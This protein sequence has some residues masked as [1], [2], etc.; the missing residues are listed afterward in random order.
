MLSHNFQLSDGAIKD[1]LREV[2][3]SVL[4]ENVLFSV[5]FVIA[6]L[7]IILRQLTAAPASSTFVDQS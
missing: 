6:F 2:K 4:V 7:H 5:W 3:G 1:P